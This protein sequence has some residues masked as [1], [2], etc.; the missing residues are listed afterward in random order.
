LSSR[1]R[2]M[3]SL[4]AGRPVVTILQAFFARRNTPSGRVRQSEPLDWS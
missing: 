2:A 1:V 4:E 3:T